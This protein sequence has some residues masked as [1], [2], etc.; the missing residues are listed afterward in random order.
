MLNVGEHCFDSILAVVKDLLTFLKILKSGMKVEA[1]L[2]LFDLLLC[3]FK[4]NSNG[5]QTLCIAFPSS[6]SILEEA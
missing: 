3:L 6:F 4:F 2:N 5:F 1:L